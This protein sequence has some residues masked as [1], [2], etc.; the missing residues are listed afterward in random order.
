MPRLIL[1]LGT[2][3]ECQIEIEPGS[4][5]LGRS[6]ENDFSIDHASISTNHCQVTLDNGS[7]WVR[8]LGSTNGTFIDSSPIQM[9]RLRSGQTLKLGDVEL[10]FDGDTPAELLV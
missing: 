3:Q 6:Q 8:D 7:V 5:S 1:N 9:A 10:L 4:T 2:P